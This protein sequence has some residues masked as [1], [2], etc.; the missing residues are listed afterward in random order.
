MYEIVLN[1]QLYTRVEKRLF[2]VQVGGVASECADQVSKILHMEA[3][4]A[5]GT[6]MF[7]RASFG[8]SLIFVIKGAASSNG[9][10]GA[11][12]IVFFQKIIHQISQVP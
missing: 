6:F 1:K 3:P 10:I 7:L 5:A 2:D 11:A 9:D 12:R 8:G 4:S